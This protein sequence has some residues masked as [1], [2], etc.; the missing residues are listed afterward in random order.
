MQGEKLGQLHSEE[1]SCRRKKITQKEGKNL[2]E[3]TS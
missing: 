1:K 2:M 3:L